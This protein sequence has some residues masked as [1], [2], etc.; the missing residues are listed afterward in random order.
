MSKKT[1]DTA[2]VWDAAIKQ[3]KAVCKKRLDKEASCIDCPMHSFISNYSE[4][5][6]QSNLV[7]MGE[8]NRD[9]EGAIYKKRVEDA[10][11]MLAGNRIL[12]VNC[13]SCANREDGILCRIHRI[14]IDP[15][16]TQCASWRPNAAFT[17]SNT[18]DAKKLVLDKPLLLRKG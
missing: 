7:F 1:K 8:D 10:R 14:K 6:M 12:L 18:E 13:I 15:A 3:L 4:C 16:V 2:E 9:P 17:W 11:L 5:P